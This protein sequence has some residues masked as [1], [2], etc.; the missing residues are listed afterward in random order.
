MEKSA[1]TAISSWVLPSLCS[2]S[3]M[4]DVALKIDTGHGVH[5]GMCGGEQSPGAETWR[6]YV[7]L[8]LKPKALTPVWIPEFSKTSVW[9]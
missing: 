9:D 6:Q 1:L 2:G 5:V 3:A 8:Y 7:L 4:D